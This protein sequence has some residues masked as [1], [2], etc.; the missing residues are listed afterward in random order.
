[1]TLPTND[2]ADNPYFKRDHR[3]NYPQTSSFNQ[4]TI[5]GLLSLGSAASPR[6]AEGDKGKAALATV[7]TGELSLSQVL[8]SV[9]KDVVA[10]DALDKNGLPPLPP[11]LRSKVYRIVPVKE[12]G[13]FDE[14][15]YPVRTF[16]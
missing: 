8:G 7:E 12:S 2:I 16:T 9:S 3:R 14:R 11:S 15:I 5:A 4:S 10:G 13:M 6:I 1:M